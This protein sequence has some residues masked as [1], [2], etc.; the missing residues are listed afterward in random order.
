MRHLAY[1]SKMSY[2]EVCKEANTKKKA[3]SERPKVLPTKTKSTALEKRSLKEEK[4]REKQRLLHKELLENDN[5]E[6]KKYEKLLKLKKKKN[7]ALSKSFSIDGLDCMNDMLCIKVTLKSIGIIDLL[8]LCMGNKPYTDGS[9]GDFTRDTKDLIGD[10]EEVLSEEEEMNSE[11]ENG[12]ELEEEME[13]ERNSENAEFANIYFSFSFLFTRLIAAVSAERE[14][15]YGDQSTS[16]LQCALKHEMLDETFASPEEQAMAER[17]EKI[18]KRFINK[19]SESN[20][21]VSSRE[22]MEL[23]RT[24]PQHVVKRVFTEVILDACFTAFRLPDRL[25]ITISVLVGIL[26]STLSSNFSDV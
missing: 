13:E 1:T 20:V 17:V 18:L 23:F 6:I 5:R 25:L 11:D 14:N 21:L 3:T 16:E 9:S 10:G 4:R 12:E 15:I 7:N 24:N 26:H 22:V 8:E 2:E 19:L